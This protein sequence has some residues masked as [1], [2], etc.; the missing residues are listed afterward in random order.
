MIKQ[1]YIDEKRK[2][3]DI[4]NN[5]K[6]EFVNTYT[7]NT[8]NYHPFPKNVKR[9]SN[10][11][12][13]LDEIPFVVSKE[14]DVKNLD[15][16]CM[17][18]WITLN[19]GSKIFLKDRNYDI[20]LKEL[21]TMYLFKLV[22]INTANYDIVSYN[23]KLFLAS[24]CFLNPNEE[25]I[26]LYEDDNFEVL[27]EFEEINPYIDY[28]VN[29]LKKNNSH[30][31][32]LKTVLMDYLYGNDD[33]LPNNFL[34]IK[35]NKKI[36]LA[37]LLDNGET[38]FSRESVLY[39]MIEKKS[40][41]NDIESAFDYILNFEFIIYWLKYVVKNVNISQIPD[42]L[43]KEK[44][45]TMDNKL[46]SDFEDFIKESENYLNDELKSKGYSFKIKLT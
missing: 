33:R 42:L 16:T 20:Y 12:I 32:F 28:Y 46:Y 5:K 15:D 8:S 29:Q 18:L 25:L 22:K 41:K 19:N 31:K 13:L 27:P 9:N 23:D 14:E 17:S 43:K 3:L 10:G 1:R 26:R 37:P 21:F 44:G 40:D 4:S 35:S 34:Y 38:F 2:T 6:D 36:K 39:P 11:I 7:P 24:N 45:I 30:I